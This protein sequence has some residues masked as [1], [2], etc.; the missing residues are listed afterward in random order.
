M[1]DLANI[2]NPKIIVRSWQPPKAE[3]GSIIGES[4]FDF[5]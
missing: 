4:N 1:F 5:E 3:D 2:N